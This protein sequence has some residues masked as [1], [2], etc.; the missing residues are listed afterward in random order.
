[1]NST[2]TI[3]RY[4][5]CFSTQRL[6]DIVTT[7]VLGDGSGGLTSLEPAN[8][9]SPVC[10]STRMQPNDHISMARS[11]GMPSSTSGDR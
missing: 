8:N 2:L 11:Y 10:I 3:N 6:D 7:A 9:A 1:M 4:P 5:G